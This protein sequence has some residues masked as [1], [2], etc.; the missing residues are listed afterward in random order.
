MLRTRPIDWSGTREWKRSK[1]ANEREKKKHATAS[2]K[3]EN[4]KSFRTKTHWR[5]ASVTW[6]SE[7]FSTFSYYFTHRIVLRMIKK[8]ILPTHQILPRHPPSPPPSTHIFELRSRQFD[9]DS[10]Q[11][12]S[13]VVFSRDCEQLVILTF[14]T[15]AHFAHSGRLREKTNSQYRGRQNVEDALL[16]MFYCLGLIW[17]RIYFQ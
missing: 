1:N 3:Y 6:K 13:T 11:Y 8:C 4:R 9:V 2:H 17:F 14:F 15:N 12:E 7:T 10:R 16:L 5:I